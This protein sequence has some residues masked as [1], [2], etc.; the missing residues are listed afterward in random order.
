MDFMD[1]EAPIVGSKWMHKNGNVYTVVGL[2]NVNSTKPEYAPSVVY[3]GENGLVWSRKLSEWHRSFTK[4]NRNVGFFSKT[5]DPLRDMVTKA[6]EATGISWERCFAVAVKLLDAG[7]RLP[8]RGPHLLTASDGTQAYCG[9]K[10]VCKFCI[11]EESEHASTKTYEEWRDAT[12]PSMKHEWTMGW[13][14]VGRRMEAAWYAAKE[15]SKR[16]HEVKR[17]ATAPDG[18]IYD[19]ARRVLNDGGTVRE[20]SYLANFCIGIWEAA[21][22]REPTPDF[23]HSTCV[24]CGRLMPSGQLQKCNQTIG[25][26]CSHRIPTA[27]AAYIERLR[28]HEEGNSAWD[29]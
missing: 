19:I 29:A 10:D 27:V 25:G 28:A 9:G 8:P 2:A 5:G 13:W 14:E 11:R 22:P 23:P 3:Q 17:E 15:A 16:L 7:M 24:E 26:Y 6:A 1:Y 18:T 21:K 12:Y 20:V 4:L